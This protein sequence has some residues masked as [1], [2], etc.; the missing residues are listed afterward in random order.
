MSSLYIHIPFCLSKC[1][2]CSFSSF[3]A[4]KSLYDQYIGAVKDEL[5]HLVERE[6]EL[7]LD[8]LFIGGGTPTCLPVSLHLCVVVV[9]EF[10]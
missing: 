5:L 6:G 4:E 10:P 3:V 9:Q 8:T 2:Y 7:K 1:H